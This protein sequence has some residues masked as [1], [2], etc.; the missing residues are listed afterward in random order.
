LVKS[1]WPSLLIVTKY[2]QSP[3]AGDS[4]AFSGYPL[5]LARYVD[6]VA[7]GAGALPAAW[8][9]WTFWQYTNAGSRY[10]GVADSTKGSIPAHDEDLFRG[11]LADV[12]AL[13]RSTFSRSSGVSPTMAA[14]LPAR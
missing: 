3:A 4:T 13:A 6:D 9:R 7:S 14:I 2:N 1:V 11:S 10:A 5:Y 8:S 12:Q